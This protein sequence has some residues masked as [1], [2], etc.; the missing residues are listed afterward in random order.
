MKKEYWAIIMIY[1]LMQLIDITGVNI[2][3]SLGNKFKDYSSYW[4][5]LT[6]IFAA[7][8]I[9]LL[10]RK[11]CLVER[12]LDPISIILWP[13]LGVVLAFTVQAI[14]IVIETNILG[15]EQG[16]ENTKVLLSL[17]KSNP[18]FIFVICLL[19]PILEE[20]VFRK[21]IFGSLFPHLGFLMSTIISSF[22]F[23]VIHLDLQHLLIYI[24]IGIVFSYLYVKTKKIIIPIFAHILMNIIVILLQV[25]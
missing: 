13:F 25:L 10:L 16:S 4:T 12:K 23:G 14:A 8:V 7:T 22:I 20:I 1:I 21:V 9:I 3:N 18:L 5:L 19:A 6:F 2:L 11:E 24:L 17:V 15:I